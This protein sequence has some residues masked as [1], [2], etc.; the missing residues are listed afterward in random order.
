MTNRNENCD[1]CGFLDDWKFQIFET[2]YWKVDICENQ[3]YLGRSYITLKRHS[4]T[5]S[6]VTNEE[7][8][9]FKQ[10]IITLESA[11]KKAF[12][13]THFNWTCLMNDAYKSNPAYPH[14]HWHLRPR[15]SHEVEFTGVVF[16]DPEFGHH[17]ARSKDRILNLSEKQLL[18]IV[19][20]VKKYF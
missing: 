5:L 12:D 4:P 20:E 1:I 8:L 10:L 3:E 14:V 15:Y 17:Y 7:W 18:E 16:K 19:E 2:K 9:D 11:F 13:A 6:E